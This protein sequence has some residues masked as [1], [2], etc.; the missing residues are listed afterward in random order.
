M[1]ELNARNSLLFETTNDNVN[2]RKRKRNNNNN[3]T[4]EATSQQKHLMSNY[5]SILDIESEFQCDGE[6][7]SKFKEHVQMH[8]NKRQKSE[9]NQTTS[10]TESPSTSAAAA[11]AATTNRN[12]IQ[13]NKHTNSEK[14]THEN[15]H[16]KKEKVPPIHVFDVNAKELISFIKNGLKINNFKIKEF[17]YKYNKIVLF[18]NSMESFIRV[19]SHLQVTDTKF[20]TFTPKCIK[21]K[22]F[23]LKGLSADNDPQMIYDELCNLQIE[24]LEF[25]KVSH[26][27]TSKSK[28]E[29]YNLPIFLVQINANSNI[30][31]LKSIRGLLHRCVHWEPLRKPEIPQCRKCQGFFHSASNCFLERRCVKCNQKHEIGKCHLANVA[32]NEREKLFCVLCN[33]SGHPASYKGCEKYKELQKKIRA[34]RQMFTNNRNNNTSYSYTNPNVSFANVL[35]MKGINTGAIVTENINNSNNFNNNS[36]LE[37]LKHSIDALSNQIINFQKQLNTQASRIDTLF[38]ILEV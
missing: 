27:I 29:G 30:N 28:K 35:K 18:L 19:K 36:L 16:N 10:L 17:N 2:A 33:K 21:T 24:D 34:K 5:Y 26:Y 23:L 3:I 32:V 38:S 9:D 22:T 13:T 1:S 37:N 4:M 8:N 31:Q 20:F 7:L 15:N 6:S 11:A 14:Q 12:S 25:V